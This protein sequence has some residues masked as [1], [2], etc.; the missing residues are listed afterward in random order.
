MAG[1]GTRSGYL[2]LAGLDRNQVLARLGM[3]LGDEVVEPDTDEPD[4]TPALGPVLDGWTLIVDQPLT[5]LIDES[6]SLERLSLGTRLLTLG[7]NETVM[8]SDAAYYED[9]ARR[10]WVASCPDGRDWRQAWPKVAAP[11]WRRLLGEPPGPSK[12]MVEGEPPAVLG[13]LYTDAIANEIRMDGVDY[14]FEIPGALVADT[15]RGAFTGELDEEWIF[16]ALI[17]VSGGDA[18][19]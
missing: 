14:Q 3:R 11:W 9:G 17:P 15:T 2:L 12:L 8:Y 13:A 6:F 16:R 4:R 10:W 7:V 5:F 19:R 18:G 1:V